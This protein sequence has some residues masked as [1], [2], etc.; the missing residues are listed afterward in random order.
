M[1]MF[2][3]STFKFDWDKPVDVSYMVEKGKK[4]LDMKLEQARYE[5]RKEVWDLFRRLALNTED[6]DDAYTLKDIDEAF[7]TLWYAEIAKL[8]VEAALD[9]DRRYQEKLAERKKLH[10]GDEVELTIHRQSAVPGMV[11]K[12][13]KGY[14]LETCVD[15]VHENMVR[16]LTKEFGTALVDA[17]ECVKLGENN[18]DIVKVMESFDD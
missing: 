15:D 1:E 17:T 14:V 8:P 2:T 18:P 5:G 12:K 7:G 6:R 10:I 3:T 13:V 4:A 9:K 11:V 16:V